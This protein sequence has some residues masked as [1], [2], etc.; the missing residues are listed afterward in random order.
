[1][2]KEFRLF[3]YVKLISGIS[4]SILYDSW[5]NTFTYIS[6]EEAEIIK[7]INSL[8]LSSLAE[9]FGSEEVEDVIHTLNGS[10]YGFYCSSDEKN[11]FLDLN[12]NYISPAAIETIIIDF[13]KYFSQEIFQKIIK[14]SMKFL[15]KSL[16]FRFFT[17]PPKNVISLYLSELKQSLFV[18]IELI[19]PY[20]NID[21]VFF[22]ELNISKIVLF[23]SPYNKIEWLEDKSKCVVYYT[24]GISV[25]TCGVIDESM[26]ILD[27]ENYTLSKN[28]NSCL[29]KKLSID[30]NGF[31]KNCPAM[32]HNYGHIRNINIEDVIN[33]P[34]FQ[35]WWQIKKDDIEV[36]KDC[37]LRYFCHDCRA[38]TLNNNIYGKPSKC[39]YNPYNNSWK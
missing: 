3:G 6:N 22:N 16:L 37:E 30:S 15:T 13:G 11:D 5:R 32:K 18:N 2:N 14:E 23:N 12:E 9:A 31:I 19:M 25:E 1:M 24:D 27:Y 28:F 4:K 38:Y 35:K 29:Y 8:P 10:D 39:K 33:L 17:V 7:Q 36:C 20:Q 21:M 34:E 26:F